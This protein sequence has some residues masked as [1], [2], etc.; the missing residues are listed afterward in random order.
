MVANLTCSIRR[1]FCGTDRPTSPPVLLVAESDAK[2]TVLAAPPAPS[3]SVP[4]VGC[5]C[6]ATGSVE[7]KHF[8]GLVGWS[9]W[10]WVRERGG[11]SAG[12]CGS[13]REVGGNVRVRE[14]SAVFCGRKVER[15][16]ER[17]RGKVRAKELSFN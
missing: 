6:S 11:V 16:E 4:V 1:T 2:S 10:V 14:A 17:Q 7:S 15:R 8:W 3:S 13:G 9:V 5:G 12:G